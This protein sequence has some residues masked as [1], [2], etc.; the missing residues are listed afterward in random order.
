MVKHAPALLALLALVAVCL[1]SVFTLFGQPE[2]T[3]PIAD[4]DRCEV[5]R[6]TFASLSNRQTIRLQAQSMRPAPGRLPKSDQIEFFPVE[7]DK[8][9]NRK[10]FSFTTQ[11][12]AAGIFSAGESNLA[13]CFGMAVQAP[14][15]YRGSY[16]QFKSDPEIL[17]NAKFRIQTL[18]SF[19]PIGFSNDGKHAV[20]YIEEASGAL[21]SKGTLVLLLKQDGRWKMI[22]H[23]NMWI[24]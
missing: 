18:G 6:V 16:E 12:M 7:F 4:S 9:G 10:K 5:Y 23:A 2:E 11:E 15:F 24:S 20:V 14:N 1:A 13:P 3:L 17:Q 19:S 21:N 8:K 22:G